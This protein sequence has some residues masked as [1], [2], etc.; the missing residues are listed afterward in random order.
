MSD[1]IQFGAKLEETFQQSGQLCVGIDPH[2]FLLKEWGLDLDERSLSKFGSQVID[3]CHSNCGIV[4][5]QVAFFE[6]AGQAGYRSLERVI[7]Y[8]RQANLMIIADAKRGDI[9]STMQAYGKAWLGAGSSL[10][11]DALTVSPYLGTEILDALE[12]ETESGEKA[13]FVL[14]RTSNSGSERFQE[15][16]LDSNDPANTIS[17]QVARD[18]RKRNQSSSSRIGNFGIV[19]GATANKPG[20]EIEVAL[21][22]AEVLTPILAPGF[23]HQGA[24][25]GE[26]KQIFGDLSDS[27]IAT[28]SR[29]VLSKGAR[30]LAEAIKSSN[31]ELA[32]GLHE[33]A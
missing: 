33:T 15:A 20:S 19:L 8:A 2:P 9:G 3:A 31:L 30:G 27:V 17:L 12:R 5:I 23:G 1:S 18:V 4:K 13:V 28:V 21:G 26:V 25:L 29:S 32:E 7:A 11:C 24:R 16:R 14:A 22:S 10:E 6:V